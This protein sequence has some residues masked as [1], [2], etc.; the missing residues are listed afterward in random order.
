[1][2]KEEPN[3]DFSTMMGEPAVDMED[4]EEDE[5]SQLKMMISKG[6]PREVDDAYSL[7]GD[8]AFSTTK[9]DKND[10]EMHRIMVQRLNQ[11]KSATKTK[12]N[13][14]YDH[15][16]PNELDDPLAVNQMTPKEKLFVIMA[17]SRLREFERINMR[18]EVELWDHAR[19]QKSKKG[20]MAELQSKIMKVQET[21]HGGRDQEN[22]KSGLFGRLRGR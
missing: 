21:I 7:L 1:M 19:T 9:Y 5:L 11:Q 22:Q 10:L 2:A 17:G 4:E 13:S 16:S 20:W 12:E 15:V 18:T 8:P 6:L 14:I 3:P